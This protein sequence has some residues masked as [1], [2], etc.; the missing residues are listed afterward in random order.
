[1]ELNFLKGYGICGTKIASPRNTLDFGLWTLDFGLW[2]LD[3]GL[4]TLDLGLWT[5]DFGLCAVSANNG[6]EFFVRSNESIK[7]S[8]SNNPEMTM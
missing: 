1:M 8:C 7:D 5:L 6:S 3:F 2:T 4:W